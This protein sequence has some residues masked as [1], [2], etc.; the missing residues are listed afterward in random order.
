MDTKTKRTQRCDTCRL[1]LK[2]KIYVV[3]GQCRDNLPRTFYVT[4][5]G[6]VSR[7]PSTYYDRWCG[8]YEP[9]Q[10]AKQ[11][12]EQPAEP[13]KAAGANVYLNPYIH[14]EIEAIFTRYYRAAHERETGRKAPF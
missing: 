3:Q 2:S 4:G 12:A 11:P 7:W 5:T 14:P 10:T 1:W 9:T 6:F 13:V 8:A